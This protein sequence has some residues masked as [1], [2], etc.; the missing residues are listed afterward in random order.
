MSFLF[1]RWDMLIPWRVLYHF[2]PELRTISNL[3]S[4]YRYQFFLRS[5][6]PTR[7]PWAM[8][9]VWVCNDQLGWF[10]TRHTMWPCLL[11]GILADFL[12]VDKKAVLVSRG[13]LLV[14]RC[15][16]NTKRWI[17]NRPELCQLNLALKRKP[18]FPVQ[19]S[20]RRSC[21]SD[22]NLAQDGVSLNHCKPT[23]NIGWSRGLHPR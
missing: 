7:V 10:G 22:C 9:C 13:W 21:S 17:G 18:L 12:D 1:P 16:D 4:D 23:S 2:A 15:F 8:S 20:N 3:S 14:C 5:W 6:R 19:W 11:E